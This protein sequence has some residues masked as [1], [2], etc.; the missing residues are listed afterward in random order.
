MTTVTEQTE[1][2]LDA[3]D[4]YRSVKAKLEKFWIEKT[5]NECKYNQSKAANRLGMSRG[6]LRM[7]LEKY[8]GNKYFRDSE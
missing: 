8:F 5:M 3:N 7:K 1:F 4:T 2:Y 6:C